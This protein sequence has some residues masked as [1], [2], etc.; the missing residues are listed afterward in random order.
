MKMRQNT[1]DI[2]AK[3]I[4]RKEN[5]KTLKYGLVSKITLE[6]NFEEISF[7]K[8]SFDISFDVEKD[9]QKSITIEKTSFEDFKNNKEFKNLKLEKSYLQEFHEEKNKDFFK[10]KIQKNNYQKPIILKNKI[11]TFFSAQSI[12]IEIEEDTTATI[13]DLLDKTP[14]IKDELLK[15]NNKTKKAYLSRNIFVILGKNSKIDYYQ[16]QDINNDWNCYNK[17]IAIAKENTEI[18]WQTLDLGGKTVISETTTILKEERSKTN[19]ENVSFSNKDQEYD[20]LGEAIHKNKQT[21]S[22]LKAK[23]AINN[24]SKTLYRGNVF[25]GQEAT[26]SEGYQKAELVMLDEESIADGIPQLLI[27]NNDVKCSHA[28]A[29]GRLDEEKI[30][31]LMSRGLDEFEAKKELI[32]GFFENFIRTIKLEE[33]KTKLEIEIEEKMQ[34]GFSK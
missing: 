1:K 34:N 15:T 10:I 3:V 30:F 20:I 25:I 19:I 14:E 29:V 17:K 5:F 21:K 26:E 7:E 27:D 13:I 24:N 8:D 22:N 12:I 23:S 16:I 9:Q 18:N 31:Y 33:I 2:I 6:Q 4:K 32:K 11:K 28:V